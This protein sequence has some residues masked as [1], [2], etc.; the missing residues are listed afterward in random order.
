M[1]ADLGEMAGINYTFRDSRRM[2]NDWIV[3]KSDVDIV[4]AVLTDGDVGERRMKGS[5]FM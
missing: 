4:T 2:R 5:W 1:N 3:N